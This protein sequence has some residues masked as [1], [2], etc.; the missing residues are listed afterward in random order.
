WWGAPGG[1]GISLG[2]SQGLYLELAPLL[3]GRPRMFAKTPPRLPRSIYASN[4]SRTRLLLDCPLGREHLGDTSEERGD[5][6]RLPARKL[7]HVYLHAHVEL[8][9][10]L[11]GRGER[12]GD[13]G[14]LRQR[15]ILYL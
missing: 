1:Y 10:A 8:H 15:R 5:P 11:S 3:L 2:E 12:R 4:S 6:L 9:D 13:G 7:L 14:S